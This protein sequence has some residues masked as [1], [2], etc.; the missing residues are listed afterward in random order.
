[1]DH[2]KDLPRVVALWTR[3]YLAFINIF[4]GA[5]VLRAVN[6]TSILV[7]LLKDVAV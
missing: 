3:A 1:M 7:V 6:F 5:W 4:G 2:G